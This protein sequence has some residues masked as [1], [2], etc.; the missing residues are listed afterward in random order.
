MMHPGPTVRRSLG[1]R[2]GTFGIA[3]ALL[4]SVACCIASVPVA[5]ASTVPV[6]QALVVLQYT[7]VARAAPSI[8]ARPVMTVAPRRPLT[9]AATVLPALGYA[10][11]HRGRA[12]V[13]VRLPGRPNSSTGWITRGGTTPSWTP[14]RLSV[15]LNARRVTVYERGRI[16]RRFPAVVGAPSTPT[17]QGSFF[18]EESLSLSAQAAGAPFA[19]ATSARS[20]VLQEFDGGP[21][22]IAMHGMGNLAGALGTASSHGCM[23]L[24]TPDITW[25]AMHI[26]AGV[27]LSIV[28]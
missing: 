9:G 5:S 16:V 24:D 3:A 25:L 28:G 15:D 4:L 6:G 26:V 7:H 14:W 20:D 11:R 22:Q 19:L 23:R 12:W 10:P 8:N 2:R 21:G 27:P 18:I 17:P 13:H 1:S